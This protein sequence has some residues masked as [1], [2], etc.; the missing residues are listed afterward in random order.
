VDDAKLKAGDLFL[1]MAHSSDKLFHYLGKAVIASELRHAAARRSELVN[2]L[3]ASKRIDSLEDS[4]GGA[5]T[6]PVGKF[7]QYLFHSF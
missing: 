5:S 4:G 1:S 3:A 6:T 7:R 2:R